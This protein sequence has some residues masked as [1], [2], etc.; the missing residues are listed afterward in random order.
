VS[1]DPNQPW[2]GSPPGYQPPE[3]SNPGGYVPPP[4][5][6]GYPQSL[7]WAGGAAGGDVAWQDADAWW[8]RF[9]SPDMFVSR[10]PNHSGITSSISGC[11]GIIRICTSV[12][13]I[14]ALVPLPLRRP[15]RIGSHGWS[16]P[17]RIAFISPSCGTLASGW[18][19][20][21]RFPWMNASTPFATTRGSR[22]NGDGHGSSQ[23]SGELF[24][25][26]SF[27]GQLTGRLIAGRGHALKQVFRLNLVSRAARRHRRHRVRRRDKRVPIM[28]A[29][30]VV[31]RCSGAT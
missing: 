19:S 18:V 2:W 29:G 16:L 25:T 26:A 15:L 6:P 8:R 28:S 3:G 21:R 10:P 5:G 14:A 30:S 4:P 24:L 27:W 23:C 17:G 13:P 11:A 31:F 7:H 12:R 1:Y 20:T 22:W 9:S